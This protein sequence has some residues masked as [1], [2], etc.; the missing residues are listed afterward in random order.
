MEGRLQTVAN[1]FQID[2]L[3]I[4]VDLVLSYF[5]SFGQSL[6]YKLIN[7]GSSSCAGI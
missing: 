6:L 4:D 5:N 7:A 1:S 3:A 2:L